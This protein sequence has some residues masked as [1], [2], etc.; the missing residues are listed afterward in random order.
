M[1]TISGQSTHMGCI[2][3]G[4]KMT[5]GVTVKESDREDEQKGMKEQVIH[6]CQETRTEGPTGKKG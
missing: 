4:D 3:T 1:E 6:S 2:I 5:D